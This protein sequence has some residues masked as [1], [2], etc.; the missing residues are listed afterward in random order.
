LGKRHNR[1]EL[2]QTAQDRLDEKDK[3]HSREF[4]KEALNKSILDL[5]R[6]R[7]QNQR[8]PNACLWKPTE[9]QILTQQAYRLFSRIIGTDI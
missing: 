3:R 9:T 4:S 6:A 7:K 2:F 1:P 5:F 8:F